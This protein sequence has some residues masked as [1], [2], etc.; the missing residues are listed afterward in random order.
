MDFYFYSNTSLLAEGMKGICIN[1]AI[2]QLTGP[3]LNAAEARMP[4]SLLAGCVGAVLL[5]LFWIVIIHRIPPIISAIFLLLKYLS[6][7]NY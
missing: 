4:H 5:G 1:L 2:D 7:D 3:D 6:L